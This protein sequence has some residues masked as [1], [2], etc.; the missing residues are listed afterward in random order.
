MTPGSELVEQVS[1]EIRIIRDMVEYDWLV[2]CV[3]TSVAIIL[4][5]WDRNGFDNL[6]AGD[7]S[8]YNA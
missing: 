3:P 8:T 4:G 5:H 7:S 6:I 2:G 1:D